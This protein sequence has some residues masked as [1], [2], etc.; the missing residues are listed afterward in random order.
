MRKADLI[1]VWITK[2][3]VLR[4]EIMKVSR[5]VAPMAK[6]EERRLDRG[7]SK[8]G[9]ELALAPHPKAVFDALSGN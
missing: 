6:N 8:L 9:F 1:S 4:D 2:A 3:L 7:V 5:A